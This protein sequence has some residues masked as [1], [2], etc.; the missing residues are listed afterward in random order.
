MMSFV[1][2]VWHSKSI[3]GSNKTR[4]N[5][6]EI[7]RLYDLATTQLDETERLETLEKC[8][9]RINEVCG[10]VP[11]YQVNVVR[12]YNSNLQ[13]INVS[14]SGNINWQYVSWAD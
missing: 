10:Q 7:D 1:E 14:A 13:G 4:V 9:A 6:P 3:N 12:A 5:D 2:G 11:M 8:T